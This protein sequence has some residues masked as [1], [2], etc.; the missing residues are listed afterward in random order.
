VGAREGAA[1]VGVSSAG[2]GPIARFLEG[3]NWVLYVAKGWTGG[4]LITAGLVLFFG[5]YGVPGLGRDGFAR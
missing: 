5:D 4:L 1:N 2:K 3:H